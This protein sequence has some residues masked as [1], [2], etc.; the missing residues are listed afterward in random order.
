[1][2]VDNGGAGD[3]GM[4]PKEKL[5][6]IDEFGVGLSSWEINFVDDMLRRVDERKT[7]MTYTFAQFSKIDDIWE[8]RVP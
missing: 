2:L 4:S 8:E 5:M 3:N 1:M 6:D 7:K